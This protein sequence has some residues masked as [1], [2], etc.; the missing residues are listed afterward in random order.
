MFTGI[1]EEVGEV[2]EVLVD[3]GESRVRIES[4]FVD[5]LQE[6]QSVSVNG[7]CLTVE[8]IGLSWFEVFLSRETMVKTSF[9]EVTVGDPVNLERAMPVE[10]RFDGHLVQGHVDTTTEILGVSS[11]GED[12]EF[13][14][15]LPAGIAQYVVEKGSISVDG[16]SLTVASVSR[17]AFRVAVIP[18]T[19][20]E[21]GLAEKKEGDVVNLE[22]DVI[23]KYVERLVAGYQGEFPS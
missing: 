12:W 2:S 15:R 22:V 13:T 21:T 14:F 10:G 11:V 20:N 17:D 5:E 16:I 19:W 23:A 8:S 18:V 6:G 3:S 7:V 1:I 9:N 4:S